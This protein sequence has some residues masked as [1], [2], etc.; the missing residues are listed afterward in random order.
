PAAPQLSCIGG[1]SYVD[2][3]GGVH[4]V[5]SADDIPDKYRRRASQLRGAN[6][7][8]AHVAPLE[9]AAPR[10]SLQVLAPEPPS[11]GDL[12]RAAEE[13]T[14]QLRAQPRLVEPETVQERALRYGGAASVGAGLSAQGL[15]LHTYTNS[16]SNP[17]DVR[18]VAKSA[19]ELSTPPPTQSP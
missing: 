13:A 12:R 2:A 1:C 17:T 10:A 8:L 6:L 14:Q 11:P 5:D 4:F 16:A 18:D 7:N 15:R 3:A 9:A 19:T